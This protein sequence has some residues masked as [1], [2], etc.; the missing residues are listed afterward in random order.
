MAGA[1]AALAAGAE[2]AE[3]VAGRWLGATRWNAA[4]ETIEHEVRAYAGKFPARFGIGKGELKSA[5]KGAMETAVFDAAYA[6]LV[7]EK[8]LEQRAERVRP[9]DSP[10]EPPA[11]TVAALEQVEAELEAAGFLVPETAQWQSKLGAGATEVAGLGL[12]LGRLVRVNAEFTYTTRQM[13]DLRRRL[14]TWFAQKPALTVADFREI[15]GAS[16]KFAVPLLEHCDRVGWTV[17][18]G[19]ERK[20]GGGGDYSGGNWPSTMMASP[21]ATR[22]S[23]LKSDRKFT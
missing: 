9:G 8:A 5:L 13:D 10:W 12:F 14:A 6:A 22:P 18:V 3:P 7:E 23:E 21:S 1:L 4:R 16:R 2:V 11:A 15:T 20:A 17:R 19:D